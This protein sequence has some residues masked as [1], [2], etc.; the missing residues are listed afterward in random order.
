V[1]TAVNQGGNIT[2]ISLQAR[3]TIPVV[4]GIHPAPH[5]ILLLGRQTPIPNL[6][7]EDSSREII[8][9][10]ICIRL[11][12]LQY[13]CFVSFLT[14]VGSKKMKSSPTKRA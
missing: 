2:Q 7:G 3:M 5:I 8:Y 10:I 1:L 12:I 4:L 9:P 13:I 14:K 6:A 11:C